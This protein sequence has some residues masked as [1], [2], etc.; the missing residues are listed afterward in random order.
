M[1]RSSIIL[2]LAMCALVA[3]ASAADGC[4]YPVSCGVCEN[5]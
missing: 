3:V 1:A 5:L 4:A 2:A